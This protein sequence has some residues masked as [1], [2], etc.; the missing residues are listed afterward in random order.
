MKKILIRLLI[1]IAA[2]LPNSYLPYFGRYS[3]KIRSGLYRLYTGVNSKHLNI[4][5]KVKYSPTVIIGDN[6]GIGA[7][8]IIQGPTTI[9][10]YVMMAP[11]ILIFTTNHQTSDILTPMKLQ[12]DTEPREVKIGDDVWIGQRAIILPGVTIGNGA[13]IAS[14]AVV[15]KDVSDYSV[16]GGNPAKVLKSRLYN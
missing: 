14:G 11:E 2:Q 9:G 5:R 15:T 1:S 10:N 8:S 13:I 6:T 3:K 12:G 16:V 4:Q 7:N